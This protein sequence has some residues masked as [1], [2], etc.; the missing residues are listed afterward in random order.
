MEVH[1]KTAA[2]PSVTTT[3]ASPGVMVGGAVG[4]VRRQVIETDYIIV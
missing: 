4:G 1:V 2:L 3:D